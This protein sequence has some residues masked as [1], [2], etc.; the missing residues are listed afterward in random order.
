MRDEFD[1]VEAEFATPR[2]TELAAAFDGIDDE[3]LIE[4]EDMVVT[5]TMTAT[6]SAPRSPSSASRSAA[7]RAA[8]EWRPRTRMRSPTLFVTSTHNPV[9][10]FSSGRAR[11]TA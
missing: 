2:V 11:S 5:V 9:L 7:A 1:E 6:S 10:F 4:R 3:D 8:L